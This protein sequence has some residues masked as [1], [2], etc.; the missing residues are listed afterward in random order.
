M[1]A[2][3]AAP[4]RVRARLDVSGAVARLAQLGGGLTVEHA[5][6]RA[7]ALALARHPA[8]CPGKADAVAL[9]Q[10]AEHGATL[11]QVPGAATLRLD[12]IRRRID[13]SRR[14]LA[15]GVLG[16]DD[17]ADTGLAVV[18]LNRPPV[19][20]FDPA[21]L[22]PHAAVLGTGPVAEEAI[23]RDGALRVAPVLHVALAVDRGAAGEAEAA[24]FLA[25]LAEDLARAEAWEAPPQLDPQMQEV[26]LWY[27]RRVDVLKPVS[28]LTPAEARAQARWSFTDLWNA[29]A[30]P[31]AAVDDRQLPGPRGPLT[32]RVYDPGLPRPAPC[33]IYVHGGGWVLCDL[34]SHDGLCR[35]LAL[36]GRTLVVAVDY[37]LAPE[38]KFPAPL[39]DCL[40]AIR[41]LAAHGADWG[42]DPMRLAVAGDSAGANLA[43]ACC[44]ALRDGGGPPLRCA[45]L[46][47][48]VYGLDPDTPSIADY[49][50]GSFLLSASDMKWFGD[51]Y[52][53]GTGRAHDPLARPLLAELRGLPPLYLSAAEFDPLLDDSRRLAARLEEADVPHDFV[54]WRGVIHACLHMTAMVDGI[55]GLYEQIGRFLRRHMEE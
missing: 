47:Y 48:G 10:I 3:P 1:S 19:E 16:A 7:A 36:A 41:W 37:G 17:L 54:V 30:P 32:V 38:N 53:G 51:H 29:D 33:V 26:L 12:Q 11:A 23:V 35:R 24:A 40:A 42:V 45:L 25:D 46:F 4:V 43:L 15:G 5:L 27:A 34:D 28:D 14:R 6:V 21:P 39:E 55:A 2:Q 9:V 31:V 52:L 49:G 13:K 44:L 20:G 8:L 18:C 22:P 50:D